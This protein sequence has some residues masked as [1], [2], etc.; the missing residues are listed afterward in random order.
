MC[1]IITTYCTAIRWT[2]YCYEML[3]PITVNVDKP[4][5]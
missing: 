2:S 3:R 4:K 1:I 5:L